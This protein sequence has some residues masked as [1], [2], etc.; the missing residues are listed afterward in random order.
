MEDETE[1]KRARFFF[2]LLSLMLRNQSY[3]W[4]VGRWGNTK[5]RMCFVVPA[6]EAG[7][8]RC[9]TPPPPAR[10]THITLAEAKG[11]VSGG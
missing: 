2:F 6:K 9:A 4:G 11:N 7:V 3:K 5:R 1:E 8:S 10:K